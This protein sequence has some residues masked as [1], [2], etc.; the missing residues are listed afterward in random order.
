MYCRDRTQPIDRDCPDCVD[1]VIARLRRADKA[2]RKIA[3]EPIG[4]PTASDRNVLDGMSGIAGE[5]E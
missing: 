1:D 5:A 4:E 3:F 2:L